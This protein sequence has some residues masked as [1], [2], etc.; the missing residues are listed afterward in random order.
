MPT[1]IILLIISGFLAAALI[2]YIGIPIVVRVA[3]KHYLVDIPNSR[4]SHGKPVPILGGVAILIS[5]ILSFLIFSDGYF[6]LPFQYIIASLLIIFTMGVKDDLL[7]LSPRNKILGQVLAAAIIAVLGDLRI[8]HI[9]GF[10][11][12]DE[13]GYVSS[14]LVTIFSIMVITNAINIIDGIDGLASGVSMVVVVTLGIFF[15]LFHNIDFIILAACFFGSLVV[16]FRFNVFGKKNKIFMGDTGSMVLGYVISLMIIEFNENNFYIN[17]TY[18]VNV[19]PVVL[20]GILIVPFFDMIRVIFLRIFRKRKPWEPD[21]NHIHHYL[22][23][24]GFSH[25]KAT[26][27]ILIVNILIIF[28]ILYL[29]SLQIDI[30]LLL[31]ILI[32]LGIV[33]VYIPIYIL[34]KKEKK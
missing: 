14:I 8:V 19:A 6:E 17:S 4:S 2:S 23:K 28:L 3:K 11:G 15:F 9:Y 7:N 34:K 33:L 21:H 29:Q 10:L 16:F 5:F 30:H 25:F 20:C 22:L 26:S 27:I 32:L 13:L 12:I 1:N 18:D 24:I 31:L